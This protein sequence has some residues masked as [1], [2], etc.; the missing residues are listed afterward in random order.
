MPALQ[1]DV[2]VGTG[3]TSLVIHLFV[4]GRFQSNLMGIL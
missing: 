1:V 2:F 4:D 3:C